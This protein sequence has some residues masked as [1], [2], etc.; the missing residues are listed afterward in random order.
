MNMKRERHCKNS[1]DVFPKKI[2]LC[3]TN[4]SKPIVYNN[5]KSKTIGLRNHERINIGTF[6]FNAGRIKH[7]TLICHNW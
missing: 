6:R 5:T 3:L 2:Q 4:I 1:M 7:L